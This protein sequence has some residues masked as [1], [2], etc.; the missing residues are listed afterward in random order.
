MDNAVPTLGLPKCN[1]IRS[2]KG[3]S[4]NATER[5]QEKAFKIRPVFFVEIPPPKQYS[6]ISYGPT[7]KAEDLANEIKDGK[8]GMTKE[9]IEPLVSVNT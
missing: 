8:K 1:A 9:I 5:M 3:T 2:E 4:C 6:S 7:E